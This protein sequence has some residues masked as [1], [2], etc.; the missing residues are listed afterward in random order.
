MNNR[1]S[2][3]S[4]LKGNHHNQ[5]SFMHREQPKT[6]SEFMEF[7][8]KHGDNYHGYTLNLDH[9]GNQSRKAVNMD[10]QS[11][12]DYEDGVNPLDAWVSTQ[13]YLSNENFN[14]QSQK[15]SNNLMKFGNS[16]SQSKDG[17][18]F[19]PKPPSKLDKK[20]PQ[21]NMNMG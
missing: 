19:I 18:S 4:V 21:K 14:N 12:E 1:V 13:V 8:M 20:Q 11:Y 16:N 9:S 6:L 2:F 17:Q 3:A 5:N 10:Y 7:Y 15:K